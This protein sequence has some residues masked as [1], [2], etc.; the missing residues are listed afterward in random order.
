MSH[1]QYYAIAKNSTPSPEY[2]KMFLEIREILRQMV[3]NNVELSELI[4]LRENWE[5][6]HKGKNFFE[7]LDF[8]E[9]VIKR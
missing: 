6:R 9:G 7:G 1:L 2:T 3:I 8:P 5:Q 4:T